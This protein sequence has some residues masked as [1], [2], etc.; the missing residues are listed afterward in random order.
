MEDR[1]GG[2]YDG[3][4][5]EI[6]TNG[7]ATWTHLPDRPLLTDP[8]DGPVTGLPAASTAGAATRRTG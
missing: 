2:C 7:G 8:Y 6:S 3:G 1:T 4:L 5:V